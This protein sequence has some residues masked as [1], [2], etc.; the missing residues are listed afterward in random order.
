MNT[1][2]TLSEAVQFAMTL[3]SGWNFA[4]SDE[5]YDHNT[6]FNIAQIH[7]EENPVDEDSFYLVSPSGAIGFTKNNGDSIDWLFL[8][9]NDTGEMLPSSFTVQSKVNFCPKCG[10]PVESDVHFCGGCGEKLC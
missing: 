9:Q 8:S 4:Y 1:F 6:L 10:K 5:T 7:D 2:S 3:S